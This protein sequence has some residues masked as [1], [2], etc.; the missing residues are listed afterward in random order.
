MENSKWVKHRHRKRKEK[1]R[2]CT[3]GYM[4]YGKVLQ[5]AI[6]PWV[7][8]ILEIEL[9]LQ[10][11]HHDVVFVINLCMVMNVASMGFAEVCRSGISLL[12]HGCCIPISVRENG[13]ALLWA[14]FNI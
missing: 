3:L 7:L 13:Q 14:N 4:H 11:H 2:M 8:E 9:P 5:L 1:K 6:R 10:W 12:A